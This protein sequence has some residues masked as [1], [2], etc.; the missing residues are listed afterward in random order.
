MFFYN[1][2]LTIMEKDSSE[3]VLT[4]LKPPPDKRRRFLV[5][6]SIFRME[7]AYRRFEKYFDGLKKIISE[8]NLTLCDICIFIDDSVLTYQPFKK[9]L[10][11]QVIKMP[12]V[13]VIHYEYSDFKK[14]IYHFGT[15]GSIMRLYALTNEF[16]PKYEAVYLSDVDMEPYEV[17]QRHILRMI[18]QKAD[19][20]YESRVYYNK[21]W[22][23]ANLKF[24]VLL[25]TLIST[26]NFPVSIL[27]N[28]LTELKN[29]KFNKII[30]EIIEDEKTST[31]KH[32]TNE[33]F[34][35]GMDEYFMNHFLLPYYKN[36]IALVRINP[37][38]NSLPHI[39]NDFVASNQFSS[40][41]LIRTKSYKILNS[42]SYKKKLLQYYFEL[43]EYCFK[44]N[45]E[46]VLDIKDKI[47]FAYELI[48]HIKPDL[49]V[50][51]VSP[52]KLFDS[53]TYK[54]LMKFV[55]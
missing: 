11:K 48:K 4:C 37:L 36:K 2:S 31:R 30:R 50:Y 42:N 12:H 27:T 34:I 54:Q 21:K 26:V 15:F 28:F 52:I 8:S 49:H 18:K 13:F 32:T 24:P 45:F 29:K 16:K 43:Y 9:W 25:G 51:L 19:I 1:R 40:K 5:V 7:N 6:F 55:I 35:Y 20:S 44:N 22:A 33:E 41:E 10:D 53:T 46:N 38:I 17:D 47:C 14:S 39:F 23:P 3:I